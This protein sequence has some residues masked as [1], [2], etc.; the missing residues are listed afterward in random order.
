MTPDEMTG[1]AVLIA[2]CSLLMVALSL[3]AL[4]VLL[5]A[6]TGRKR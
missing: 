2:S 3:L 6:Q 4:I 1:V 5:W